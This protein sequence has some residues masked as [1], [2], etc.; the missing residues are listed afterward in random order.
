MKKSDTFKSWEMTF[1]WCVTNS[2]HMM[3]WT[4]VPDAA[5]QFLKTL[6]S[7]MVMP[8][9]L[10]AEC[11]LP[12]TSIQSKPDPHQKPDVRDY[13]NWAKW[14]ISHEFFQ[15][16]LA[17]YFIYLCYRCS[18]TT[19]QFHFLIMGS[20]FLMTNIYSLFLISICSCYIFHAFKYVWLFCTKN[21]FS[22][23]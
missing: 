12:T 21:L 1:S 10:I 15:F 18:I 6:L 5:A 4:S 8:C 19:F 20:F 3:C 16:N 17:I 9:L 2:K 22:Q 7:N 11:Q 13:R 23:I 14:S